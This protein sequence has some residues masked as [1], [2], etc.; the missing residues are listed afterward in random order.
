MGRSQSSSFK[1]TPR[2]PFPEPG[3]T[4]GPNGKYFSLCQLGHGTFCAISKCVNLS[5]H[6]HHKSNTSGGGRTGSKENLRIAAAKVELSSFTNSG[7]L[8]GEATILAHLC[9]NMPQHMTPR[10]LDYIK[11][12]ARSNKRN[13]DDGT[14]PNNQTEISAIIMEYLAG[15][16]M[17]RMRDRHAQILAKQTN[18]FDIQSCRRLSVED[19][20]YLCRNIFLPLLQSMHDCGVIHR[21]VK[22]SNCVR[23]GTTEK[24]RD[25][26]L[27]DFGL[28]K[29]F[30]VPRDSSYANTECVWEGAWD[31]G[32]DI[33]SSRSCPPS[34][35]QGCI[36]KERNGAEFRGTSMY[37]SL[38][39]HQLRDYCR[40]D[41][42]WG[43]LYVFLDL[44]T[45][46]LPWMG[47]AAN[48]DRQM[49]QVIKEYVH[50]ERE[51][52][53]F[54][55]S[56]EELKLSE[57]KKICQ[58]KIEEFLKGAEY[59]LSKHRRDMILAKAKKNG[60]EPPPDS[61]LPPLAPPLAMM[62]DQNKIDA[63]RKAFNH[64]SKLEF[65]DKPD[66]DFIGRCMD[67]FL[68]N[69]PLGAISSAV[70]TCTSSPDNK[71]DKTIPAINWKQPC[72]KK[73]DQ[74]R[75]ERIGKGGRMDNKGSSSL[76]PTLVFLD[77][78][79]PL[80]EG[81]L[82][83]AEN[84]RQLAAAQLENSGSSSLPD[85]VASMQTNSKNNSAEVK[86]VTRLPMELQFRLAQVEY[87][88]ANPDTIP[89][90]LAFRD[91]MEL[92]T[93]LVYDT[94]D[95]SK[96]ERGNHRSNDD[97]YRRELYLRIVY[98]CI[99]AAKP[100]GNFCS[101]DCFEYECGDDDDGEGENGGRV[102][103]SRKRRRI[104]VNETSSSQSYSSK[105]SLLAFSKVFCA[106]RA[107]LDMERERIFAPPPT[108]SFGG[109]M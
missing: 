99:E 43:L 17:H 42:I 33:N 1:P 90:H 58:E 73:M 6:H 80:S 16:D 21:D 19:S 93:S 76:R 60:D 8:D 25:F 84:K 22:P 102:R 37:A 59:H 100:F 46:G 57:G 45:G 85:N 4:I 38:R 56:T 53:T 31:H 36:R 74:K 97:N 83:E 28:S 82:E 96:Y 49:C 24:D 34:Q 86:D 41:D 61:E 23:T 78:L 12:D 18:A 3:S 62:H 14:S 91:W 68:E 15:E 94:W 87:N 69:S 75:W 55:L 48:R 9:K 13:G 20:V 105:S 44:V 71:K 35:I 65:Q 107:S 109:G 39:V 27:V 67:R 79:D 7:V 63:L 50:G 30:V 11:T 54:H 47:Y 72:E 51:I 40:R 108:L 64:V 5:Y 88:A 103:R 101:R 52:V 92:A 104:N 2:P 32:N 70:D 106:L 77:D 10:F 81:V 98:Q 29:S 95:S 89:I 66:Y 26:K